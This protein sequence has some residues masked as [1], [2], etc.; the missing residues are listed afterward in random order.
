MPSFSNKQPSAGSAV[1]ARPPQKPGV[2][3][4]APAAVL[5]GS[6]NVP[7]RLVSNRIVSLL[8]L[9]WMSYPSEMPP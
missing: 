5:T 8:S 7:S 4:L 2:K 1:L 3:A 6:P 9:D